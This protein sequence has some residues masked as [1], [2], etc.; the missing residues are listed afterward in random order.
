MT[1]TNR[2]ETTL[3]NRHDAA[4]FRIISIDKPSDIT[5]TDS[6]GTVLTRTHLEAED[7]WIPERQIA[8]LTDDRY[9][10]TVTTIS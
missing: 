10:L 1:N 4:G 6:Y 3:P 7:G 5:I 2:S 9:P 8:E